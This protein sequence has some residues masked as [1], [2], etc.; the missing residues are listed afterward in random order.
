MLKNW[1]LMKNKK[2]LISIV[3][4]A[5]PNRK[6]ELIRLINSVEKSTYKT[7]EIIVVDNS[8]NSKLSSVIQNKYPKVRFIIMT[9][10]TGVL[11]FNI[12]FSN[13]KG[14]YILSLDDDCTV[15]PDTL[16]NIAKTFPQKPD[17][18]AVISTNIY[19]PPSKRFIFQNYLKQKATNLYISANMAVFRKEIFAKI[20]Y[21]DKDFFLWVHEDDLSIRILDAG[22]KIHFEPKIVVNHYLEPNRP[23][24]K[25]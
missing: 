13:S 15:N 23:F 3:T 11:G 8:Q 9:H 1:P 6:T 24:R 25:N 5:G 10:N 18:V 16:E 17:K 21:Y 20:G 14:E 4:V 22:F 19:E 7:F 12:G 2:I